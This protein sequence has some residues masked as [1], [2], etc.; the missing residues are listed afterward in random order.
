MLY[1]ELW[2]TTLWSDFRIADE[3]GEEAIKET[4]KR[5]FDGQKNDLVSITDLALVLN[6]K[7]QDWAWDQETNIFNIYYKLWDKT[8]RWCLKNL[9]WEDREYYLKKIDT[10]GILG[11]SELDLKHICWRHH[12]FA[13]YE[14]L[15]IDLWHI[16]HWPVDY[17]YRARFCKSELI[18]RYFKYKIFYNNRGDAY[19]KIWNEKLYLKD[20]TKVISISGEDLYKLDNKDDWF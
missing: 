6:E 20:A 7:A 1:P 5:V 10:V 16:E 18:W 8:H 2:E 19:F 3:H 4:Y 9:K 11:N 12:I 17:L 14:E 15:G 13:T